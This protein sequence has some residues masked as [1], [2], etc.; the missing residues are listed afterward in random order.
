[1][2][3]DDREVVEVAK[4][5]YSARVVDKPGEGKPKPKPIKK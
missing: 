5:R 4:Q 3:A 2:A 1:V